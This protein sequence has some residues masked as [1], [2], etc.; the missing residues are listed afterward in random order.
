MKKLICLV[1]CI[2]MCVSMACA[3]FAGEAEEV[4]LSG[5][6]YYE[7]SMS[8]SQVEGSWYATLLD[9]FIETVAERTDG[10][11]KITAYHNNTLGSPE[12]IYN[13][14]VMGTIDMV[15]LGMSQAGEF[16]VN[17]ITQIPFFCEDP[18]EALAV[19][20]AL[21]DAG[22]MTEYTDEGFHKLSFHPTDIQMICLVDKQVESMDDFSG[23]NIRVNSGSIISALEAFG[24]TAVSITTTEVYMS[25]TTGV[26]DGAVSSPTAMTVFAFD[27][28]C[29]YLYEVPLA[30]GGNYL[31][32]SDMAWDSLSPVLQDI[33]QE[34]SDEYL[35][36]YM[37]A[38]IEA[39]NESIE[40]FST[41]YAP[42]EE[43]LAEMREATA[44]I[45]EEWAANLTEKGYD[46]EAIMEL[47]EKTLE[48]YRAA[49][50]EVEAE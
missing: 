34:V 30:I 26:V 36:I 43:A 7:F 15:N 33:L 13:G 4:D 46:G 20:E 25:L 49:A 48:E 41:V 2:A 38:N 28:A 42:T 14:M 31:C 18:Y 50:A 1:L 3:A 8:T 35:D 47:A 16:P 6:D 17:D 12:D 11:I 45:K 23:L 40:K 19:L 39:M 37:E 24:A 44:F 9:D 27:D 29:E 21:Y 22:Y 32:I 5:E 10:H